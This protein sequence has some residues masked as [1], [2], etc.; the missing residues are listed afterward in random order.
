MNDTSNDTSEER[1]KQATFW[2]EYSQQ[3]STTIRYTEALSAAERAIALDDARK[4]AWYV[5]GTCLAMLGKYMK[6]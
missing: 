1:K 4:E 3:L 2:L 5:K 6:H